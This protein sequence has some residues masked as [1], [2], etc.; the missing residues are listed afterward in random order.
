MNSTKGR[1]P[2]I[3]ERRQGGRRLP[4][5]IAN[6]SSQPEFDQS[7]EEFP[8]VR[9]DDD[10]IPDEPQAR[11]G[12]RFAAAEALFKK[13]GTTPDAEVKDAVADAAEELVNQ[14]EIADEAQ[15][16]TT[17]GRRILPNLAQDPDPV[18]QMLADQPA[19]KRRGRKPKAEQAALDLSSPG[20]VEAEAEA[21]AEAETETETAP[22]TAENADVVNAPLAA[23]QPAVAAAGSSKQH[24]GI[25]ARQRQTARSRYDKSAEPAFGRGEG[26]KKRLPRFAR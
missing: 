26:W 23:E 9:I 1:Q 16:T 12:G 11:S 8:E 17:E 24:L 22:E 3:V 14:T 2:V 10:I 25:I 21:E 5:A 18:E 6:R 13:P 15:P 20:P 19:P 4:P 7:P